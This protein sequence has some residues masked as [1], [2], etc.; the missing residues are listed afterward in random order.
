MINYAKQRL[1]VTR[2]MHENEA[3]RRL[4]LDVLR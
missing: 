2:V 3:D 1:P 4:K